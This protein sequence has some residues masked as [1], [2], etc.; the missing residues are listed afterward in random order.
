MTIRH[1]KTA[2][3][4]SDRNDD[5]AKVRATVETIL[6]DI[7]ARGDAAVRELSQKVR[8]LCACV[9]PAERLGDR[10]ACEPG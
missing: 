7:E 8:F 2:K 9:V 3:T 4:A 1:F 10:S 5:D 6:T